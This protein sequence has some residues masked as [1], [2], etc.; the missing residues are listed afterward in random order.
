MDMVDLAKQNEGYQYLLVCINI[1]SRFA[2]CIPLKTK[3]GKDVLQGLKTIFKDGFKVNMVRTDRGMEFRSKEVNAYLKSQNVHHFYALNTE[4][5]ANYAGRLIKTLKHKLFRYMMKNRT[6][7]YIDVLQ[8]IVHSYNHTLHRSLGATPASITEEKEGESRLQQYLLR[9]DRTKR[10]TMPKKKARKIYKFK[11]NQT[12]RLSHVRSVF[13]RQY[14][15]KW[16]GEIFK[17]G[18]RFRREGVPV[19]TILDWD[20]E[21]VEGTIYEPELQAVDVDLN[22]EYHI[23]KIVKRRV[24]NKRKEVLVSWLHWPKKYNSWIPEADVKDYS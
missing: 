14:S 10:S 7:R 5:K 16:T 18:T 2:R 20:N 22:T 24:R 12:V 9:R 21:R 23:D 6:Q 15:Q 17:I 13:D 3:K 4:T 11:I 19:Y 1:L 8:D